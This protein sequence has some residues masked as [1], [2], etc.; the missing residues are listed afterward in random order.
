MSSLCTCSKNYKKIFPKLRY[1]GLKEHKKSFNISWWAAGAHQDKWLFP[2][3]WQR[4]NRTLNIHFLI[5]QW[6]LPI[7]RLP[8]AP[9]IPSLS[10]WLKGLK[11]RNLYQSSTQRGIWACAT[12]DFILYQEW[13]FIKNFLIIN[14]D[15]SYGLKFNF[16][17]KCSS[18]K[19]SV[20]CT[21]A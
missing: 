19:R 2:T 6:S 1:G 3:F 16:C 9:L 18:H 13:E 11:D 7:D 10:E 5:C 15:L 17:E 8:L 14:E 4:G 20:S 12:L 21:K